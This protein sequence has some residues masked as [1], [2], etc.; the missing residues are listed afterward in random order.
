M[1]T[2]LRALTLCAMLSCSGCN[3]TEPTPP[4]VYHPEV[5]PKVQTKADLLFQNFPES[6]PSARVKK[7]PVSNP[8]Y[9][10]VHIRQLHR[11]SNSNRTGSK[12]IFIHRWIA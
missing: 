7:Y 10:L 9:V 11:D 12:A 6:L 1:Y 8:D 5:R 2:H 4:K 3:A